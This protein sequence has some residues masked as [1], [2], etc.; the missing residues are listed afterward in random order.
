[1]GTKVTVNSSSPNR[2]LINNQQKESVRTVG[3]SP[4][5]PASID[6]V[7]ILANAAYNKANSA[8]LRTGDTMTGILRFDSGTNGNTFIGPVQAAG[9]IDVFAD[10]NSLY[11]QLNWNNATSVYVDSLG[12]YLQTENGTTIS[13]F[14]DLFLIQLNTN[15]KSWN[16]DGN[17]ALTFPDSSVQSKAFSGYAIDNVAIST[18]QS[19]FALANTKFSSSGGTITGDVSITG[20]LTLTGNTVLLNV[21]NYAVEDS[22]I[23]LAYKNYLTDSLVIGFVANYNNG[24][25]ATVHTG[26]MRDPV[27]K[28]YYLFNGYDKEP[29]NNKIDITGNNFTISTLNAD[30]NSNNLWIS[31]INAQPW[32]SSAFTQANNAFAG[33]GNAREI[34]SDTSLTISDNYI[35]ANG[36]VNVTLIYAT[37]NIGKPF[38]IYNIGTGIVTVLPRESDT[39]NGYANMIMQFRN[40]SFSVTSTGSK[41]LIS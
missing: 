27:T 12:S 18:A 37:G 9:G 3:V 38:T 40:S 6:Q 25:C 11:A 17:G 20:N 28:Q 1:M 4:V 2:I 31:G 5:T 32:I 33:I 21:A 29:S 16:F 10:S 8:V 19:A 14:R 30:I 35:F 36:T 13:A 39:I 22:L 41:W 23:Y 15:G 34:N 24:A 7:S 26:L